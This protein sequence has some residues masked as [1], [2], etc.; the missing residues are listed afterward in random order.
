MLTVRSC[1]VL[2]T[3]LLAVACAASGPSGTR[4]PKPHQPMLESVRFAGSRICGSTASTAAGSIFTFNC[5]ALPTTEPSGWLLTPAYAASVLAPQRLHAN[6][7]AVIRVSGPPLTEMDVELVRAGGQLNLP[8]TQVEPNASGAPGEVSASRQVG[9]TTIDD[10]RK[11]SWLIGVN[12]SSCADSRHIQIF[13]RSSNREERSPPLSVYLVRDPN[14][15][16]CVGQSGPNP[17]ARAGV[18]E[19]INPR[20]EGGCP[21]GGTGKLFQTC[22]TCPSLH[23]P[24]LSFYSAGSYCSWEE[25]LAVYGYAGESAVKPRICELTQ[26]SSKEACEGK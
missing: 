9:V 1:T 26:T 23:P 4:V 7:S 3:G 18:G 2:V 15:A 11:K 16:I 17:A 8:L 10:G 12:V 22:E 14:E 24:A 25:V 6:R 20:P 21:G 19:P 5:P 13:N